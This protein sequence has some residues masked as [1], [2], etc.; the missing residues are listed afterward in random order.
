M[1]VRELEA[2]E[3]EVLQRFDVTGVATV[4]RTGELRIGEASVA[5]VVGAPHRDEAFRA[6]RFVI[7][8]VKRRVP[9]WKKEFFEGGQVWIEDNHPRH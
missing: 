1:A 4:H 3:A 9:I 8:A 5:V 2:I 7:D 6:C